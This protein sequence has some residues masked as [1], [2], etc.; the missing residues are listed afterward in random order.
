M[1]AVVKIGGSQYVVEPKQKITVQLPAG[2]E[3]DTV[4]FDNVLLVA[5]GANVKIGTPCVGGAKVEA[6][7]IRRGRGK[8]SAGT[9]HRRAECRRVRPPG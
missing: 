3:K 4:G 2:A 6:R 9:K 8:K 7:V 1:I 5:D